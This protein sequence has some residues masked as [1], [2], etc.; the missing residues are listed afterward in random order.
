MR[1]HWCKYAFMG[2][3]VRFSLGGT[4]FSQNSL[5]MI[6]D[7]EVSDQK[8]RI[9]G[10]RGCWLQIE[11]R[12]VNNGEIRAEIQTVC[13]AP[14]NPTPLSAYS[15]WIGLDPLCHH[16]PAPLSRSF[17]TAAAATTIA[18]PRCTGHESVS[19]WRLLPQLAG[20]VWG[21]SNS[22]WIVDKVIMS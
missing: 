16:S 10:A 19:Q 13:Q 9:F 1:R 12:N 4:L 7:K 21:Y 8:V 18:P 20:G 14:F 6:I 22:H 2:Q 5:Q 11:K 3:S 15:Y 17:V